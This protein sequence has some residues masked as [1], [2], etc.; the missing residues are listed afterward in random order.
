MLNSFGISAP[1]CAIF[2]NG[3]KLSTQRNTIR[4]ITARVN[5]GNRR[6]YDRIRATLTL[7]SVGAIFFF[8]ASSYHTVSSFVSSVVVFAD[9]L[10]AM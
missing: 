8:E 7:G 6:M 2:Q 9:L 5:S 3:N 4:N 10:I 1:H